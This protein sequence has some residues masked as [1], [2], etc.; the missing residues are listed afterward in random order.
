MKPIGQLDTS[1]A[2]YQTDK[3]AK[4]I[5]PH[6]QTQR[7]QGPITEGNPRGS[8]AEREAWMRERQRV[9]RLEANRERELLDEAKAHLAKKHGTC[10]CNIEQIKA[11]LRSDPGLRAMLTRGIEEC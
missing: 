2:M 9:A 8:M 6:W 5:L 10:Q 1:H 11:R 4:P 3:K 7:A